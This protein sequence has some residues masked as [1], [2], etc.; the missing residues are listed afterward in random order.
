VSAD[1]SL[2]LHHVG[3][4]VPEI[5]PASEFYVSV[6]GYEPKT[7][8]IHDPTQTAFVQ[9]FA[10]P[11]ADHYVE[12]VAPDGEESKLLNASKKKI[13]LNHL[14]YRCSDIEA[15]TAQMRDQGCL[16]LEE[17]VAAVAFD[18]RRISWLITGERLLVEL[19]ERGPEGSL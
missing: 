7:A 12:L 1:L 18:G 17:P 4:V 16:V 10:L 11:G 14:C 15:A 6:L 2:A 3:I 9:F 8:V 5:E 19:V 13:P